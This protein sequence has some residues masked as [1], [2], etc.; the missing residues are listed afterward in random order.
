MKPII[1][2]TVESKFDE[3]DL[4]TRGK[5]ELNW[6]YFEV[7]SRAGGVPIV[8]PP[9]ADPGVIAGLIHGWLIPGGLDIDAARF[10]ERNHPSV[11]LQDPSRY[12]IEE[13]LFEAVSPALPILG[14]CYGCQ[15]LNVIRG[16]TLEQHLPDVPGTDVHTGGALQTY[17]FGEESRLRAIFGQSTVQGKSYHHQSVGRPGTGVRVVSQHDDG[18]VEAIESTERPWTF[19]VQWH[20][21]RTPND[22][23]SLRLF[24]DF[25]EAAREYARLTS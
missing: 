7:V 23:A 21:E 17:E 13:A 24:A 8:I 4:R 11:V 18:T 15:F 9:T 16:G 1:G 14:I 25:I 20:P 22:S 10:G 3:T 2:I 5:I 6:N 12:E 19:G